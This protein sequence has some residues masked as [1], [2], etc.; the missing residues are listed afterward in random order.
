[1]C[2]SGYTPPPGKNKNTQTSI[3]RHI[4]LQLGTQDTSTLAVCIH[5]HPLPGMYSSLFSPKTC[6]S[7]DSRLQKRTGSFPGGYKE[8]EDEGTKR[9]D[10]ARQSSCPPSIRPHRGCRSGAPWLRVRLARAVG[11]LRLVLARLDSARLDPELR[12]MWRRR[13][14][15]RSFPGGAAGPAPNA[16]RPRRARLAEAGGHWCCACAQRAPGSGWL[17]ARPLPP[18]W[19]RRGPGGCV[20]MITCR[21]RSW[22]SVC[23]SALGRGR[24][25]ALAAEEV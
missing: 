20:W 7:R 11:V 17:S 25:C 23:G 13:R 12:R 10:P 24:D 14:T 21:P 18:S 8:E 19:P 5:V 2:T 22:R 15:S 3:H 1:M 9:G 6:P 16:P 4:R